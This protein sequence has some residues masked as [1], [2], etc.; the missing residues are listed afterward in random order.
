MKSS[1]FLNQISQGQIINRSFSLLTALFVCL[2]LSLTACTKDKDK[3]VVV[4]PDTSQFLQ[5]AKDFVQKTS[6]PVSIESFTTETEI[7]DLM[8]A[9]REVIDEAVFIKTDADGIVQYNKVKEGNELTETQKNNAAQ[10]LIDNTFLELGDYLVRADWTKPNGESFYTLGVISGNGKPKF[11]PILYYNGIFEQHIPNPTQRGWDWDNFSHKVYN[12]FGML[13]VDVQFRIHIATDPNDCMITDP[14]P[15][16]EITKAAANYPGWTQRT[17]KGEIYW[18]NPKEN[19][20]CRYGSTA[21]AEECIKFAVITYA[22]SGFS[23]VEV[24]A[25]ASGDVGGITLDAKIKFKAATFGAEVTYE[26]IRSICASGS[27]P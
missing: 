23:D 1:N 16:V 21:P 27:T 26:T 12:G 19:C 24:E 14:G 7:Q 6:L 9:A 3:E 13:V 25:G 20:E 8:K 2:L 22:A 4:T 10:E 18:C 11:E 15:H 5:M 17:T